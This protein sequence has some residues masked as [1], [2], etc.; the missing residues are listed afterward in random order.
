MS[1]T[2]VYA[3]KLREHFYSDYPEYKHL[4]DGITRGVN[5]PSIVRAKFSQYK[6]RMQKSGFINKQLCERARL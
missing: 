6:L 2:I 5:I 1:I 3:H 4:N